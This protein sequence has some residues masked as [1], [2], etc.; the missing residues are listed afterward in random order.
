[1][2]IKW[3][4]HKSQCNDFGI[5]YASNGTINNNNECARE[6]KFGDMVEWKGGVHQQN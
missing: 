4:K 3:D 2:F 5:R 6:N 1:M